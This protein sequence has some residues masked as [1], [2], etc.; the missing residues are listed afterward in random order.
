MECGGSATALQLRLLCP[1]LSALCWDTQKTGR[2]RTLPAAGGFAK[3]KAQA[4]LAHSTNSPKVEVSFVKT[5]R[6]LELV[7][8]INETCALVT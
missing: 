7:F 8:I 4:W 2:S 5:K 1:D 6:V 3:G